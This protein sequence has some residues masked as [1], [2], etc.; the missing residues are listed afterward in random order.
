[1][2]KRNDNV[3]SLDRFDRTVLGFISIYIQ[4]LFYDD[5]KMNMVRAVIHMPPESL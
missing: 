1:M 3:D 2:H 5:L 4:T